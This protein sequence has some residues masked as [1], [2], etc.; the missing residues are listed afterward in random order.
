MVTKFAMGPN[1]RFRQRKLVF[2]SLKV[3]DLSEEAVAAL[4]G[5][6]MDPRH[7]HLNALMDDQDRLGSTSNP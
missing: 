3:A 7:D 1:P 2:R 5:V 4:T 6:R